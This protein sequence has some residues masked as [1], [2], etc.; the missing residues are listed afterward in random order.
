MEAGCAAVV[1]EVA[2][3][4]QGPAKPGGAERADRVMRPLGHPDGPAGRR[5]R[6]GQARRQVLSVT[7]AGR[8]VLRATRGPRVERLAQ[9]LSTGFTAVERRQLMAAAPLLERLAQTI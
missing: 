1:A 6:R 9:A 2:G 8:E 4:A 3:R 5:V 7:A